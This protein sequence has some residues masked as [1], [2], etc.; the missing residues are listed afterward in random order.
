MTFNSDDGEISPWNFFGAMVH[1][2]V[3]A[4]TPPALLFRR[5]LDK[6]LRGLHFR[7]N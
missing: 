4:P 3:A 2:G 6:R 5:A 1:E 7:E